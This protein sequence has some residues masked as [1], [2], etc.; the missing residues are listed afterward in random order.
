[1]LPFAK[2]VENM[3]VYIVISST[4]NFIVDTLMFLCI[5]TPKTVNFPFIP[6]GKLMGFK[7][8]NEH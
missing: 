8:P 3:A 1:M 2:M 6:N 4:D 7:C 5:G